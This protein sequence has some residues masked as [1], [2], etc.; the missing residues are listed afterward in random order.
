MEP[1][2]SEPVRT[3]FFIAGAAKAGTSALHQLLEKHPCVAMS[4]VKEPNYFSWDLIEQQGLYYHA[5][6]VRS[7]EEYEKLFRKEAGLL[8]GE[9]SVS[10]L[11]Y[12]QVPQR[13]FDY[14]P[15]AKIIVL[16]REPVARAESHYGMDHAL[17]LVDS[18]LEQVWK[19]SSDHPKTGLHFQQYFELGLYAKQLQRYY[20]LFPKEQLLVLLHKDLREK[21]SETIAQLLTFLNLPPF[22]L[23]PE[24]EEVNTGMRAKLPMIAVLYKNRTFRSVVRK[25]LGNTL[26]HQVKRIFFTRDKQVELPTSLKQQWHGFYQK[27][28]ESLERLI[29]R[30]LDSWKTLKSG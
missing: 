18:T 19:N 29:G 5:E 11:F 8:R 7:A 17:G 10:Y 23:I 25:V 9:S 14:N 2:V 3:G 22:P 15:Q 20:A 12:P 30:N 26:A 28:I 6:E 4:S 21:R 27:D 13:L 16:L 24:A 1:I